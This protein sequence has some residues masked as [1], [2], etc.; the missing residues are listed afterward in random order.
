MAEVAHA[1]CSERQRLLAFRPYSHLVFVVTEGRELRWR[2]AKFDWS[3]ARQYEPEPSR[4]EL[5]GEFLPRDKTIISITPLKKSKAERRA[6]FLEQ[7][8]RRLKNLAKKARKA[9]REGFPPPPDNSPAA[10]RERQRARAIVQNPKRKAK[11][12]GKKPISRAK[13]MAAAVERRLDNKIEKFE[14]AAERGEPGAACE[15]AVAR[16]FKRLNFR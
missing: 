4:F 15:L 6:I 10:Q 12:N 11:S 3:K 1:I 16:F 8:R 14:K 2:M 5:R 7:E 9:E 13:S